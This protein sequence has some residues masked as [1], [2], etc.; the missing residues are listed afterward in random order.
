M[1]DENCI[2]ADAVEKMT[3]V[4]DRSSISVKDAASML[5]CSNLQVYRLLK[6]GDIKSAKRKSAHVCLSLS[7]IKKYL[8]KLKAQISK[9][10]A[11]E[12]LN[13]WWQKH[14]TRVRS[15][16]MARQLT[17]LIKKGVIKE[18]GPRS[19]DRKSVVD[20]IND[21][22]YPVNCHEVA[23]LLNIKPDK[24]PLL[25]KQGL[26]RRIP[27]GAY[28]VESVRKLVRQRKGLISMKE[29]AAILNC[30]N[31]HMEYL[32]RKGAIARVSRNAVTL[33]SVNSY[34]KRRQ[35]TVSLKEA[36]L[37]L[38][39]SLPCIKQLQATG[40]LRTPERGR[41][42]LASVKKYINKISISI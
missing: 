11:V 23:R 38:G 26:L 25:R 20:L 12:M 10:D 22:K 37:M 19:V 35:L 41:I 7:S 29:A 17:L 39:R 5:G 1:D 2:N 32:V 13:P 24:L 30:G 8:D 3:K 33:K 21:K 4:I 28:D 15:N 34:K 40:G 6:R 9:R 27:S 31:R 16:G 36:S 42:S 18:T 14:I